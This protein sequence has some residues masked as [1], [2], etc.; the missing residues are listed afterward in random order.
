MV[1]QHISNPT[2]NETVKVR[3]EFGEYH[4]CHIRFLIRHRSNKTNKDNP[5][6]A[7]AFL[8]LVDEVY[9][10]TAVKD[11]KHDLYVYS[12]REKNTTDLSAL[13]KDYLRLTHIR[14]SHGRSVFHQ[15]DAG[16]SNKW[17]WSHPK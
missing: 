16:P 15:T 1:Y 10:E 5:P 13:A 8:K 4:S 11:G 12:L 14:S 9:G 3:V 2:W 6:Y 17:D 7:V